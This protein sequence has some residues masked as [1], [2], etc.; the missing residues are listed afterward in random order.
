LIDWNGD[1][2]LCPQDWQRRITMGNMM[3]E[4]IF[5]IWTGKILSKYRSDLLKGNRK[6]SPCN[7]CN[8]QGTLL[9]QNHAKIWKEIY[10]I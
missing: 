1:I 4:E 9:G 2:F 3:Q 6:T 10:K 5:N 7:S 8:A